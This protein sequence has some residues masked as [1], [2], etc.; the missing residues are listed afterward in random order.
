VWRQVL[1]GLLI[2]VCGIAIGAG[3]T[4]VL[5]KRVLLGPQRKP[6]QQVGRALMQ[7]LSGSLNLTPQQETQVREIM[8]RHFDRT[9]EIRAEARGEMEQE[10][11]AMRDEVAQVLTPE[12]QA[13][14]QAHYQRLQRWTAPATG[15]RP[16]GGGRW[17]PGP[18]GAAPKSPQ[19]SPTR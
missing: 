14:W 7:R 18:R 13:K 11:A 17:Q 9:A 19:P 8:K 4:V 16:F 15:P 5:A 12:Q 2:L 6:P 10:L 1:L 3:G